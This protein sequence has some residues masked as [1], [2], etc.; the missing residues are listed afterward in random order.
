MLEDANIKVASVASD[1][2]GVSGRAMLDAL[3]AVDMSPE[4]MPELASFS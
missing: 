4:E 1:M 3:L 2:F